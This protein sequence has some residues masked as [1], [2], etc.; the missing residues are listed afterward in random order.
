MI[1]QREPGETKL[2]CLGGNRKEVFVRD[3]DEVDPVLHR[4]GKYHAPR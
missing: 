1:G 4:A 3:T 2:L